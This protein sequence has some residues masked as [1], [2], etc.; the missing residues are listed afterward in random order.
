MQPIYRTLG[1]FWPLLVIGLL[2]AATPVSAQIINTDQE[3]VS[4]VKDKG[5]IE[6]S[7]PAHNFQVLLPTP[8]EAQESKVPASKTV[9]LAQSTYRALDRSGTAIYAIITLRLPVAST[10][11]G[12]GRV[13]IKRND[14]D[15][16][17]FVLKEK[18]LAGLRSGS[19]TCNLDDAREV[20]S[21]VHRG[22]EYAIKGEGC[23]TGKVR[24]YA[25]P[26]QMFMV[27]V[28]G[29][30]GER[31]FFDSFLLTRTDERFIVE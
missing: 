26:R 13:V 5:W 23:I 3:R 2:F 6:F 9:T 19:N 17:M 24:L 25:T 27:G 29:S 21:G 10:A 31:G 14:Y 4:L 15:K 11:Q 20:L 12:A 22:R 8:P 1:R 28:I 16:L 18:F 7:D 30:E